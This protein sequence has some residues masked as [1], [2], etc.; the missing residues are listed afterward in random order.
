M[1]LSQRTAVTLA[2]VTKRHRKFCLDVG[3]LEIREGESFG[4]IGPSGAGKSTL[5]RLISGLV[6]PDAGEVI[7]FGVSA[8]RHLGRNRK[9]RTVFQDLALFPHL[10][11]REQL[12]LSL[13]AAGKGR[14]AEDT[15]QLLI[16][17]LGLAHRADAKPL[18]LSGGERQRV[19]LGRALIA[20]PKLL[21]MDEPMTALD[22]GNRADLWRHIETLA[23]DTSTT[24]VVVTHDPDVA[25]TRCDRVAVISE[26]KLLRVG[27]PR[28]LYEDPRSEIVLQLLGGA[29]VVGLLGARTEIDPSRILVS[30]NPLEDLDYVFR[31]QLVRAE[32]RGNS[33]DLQVLVEGEVIR[34]RRPS[35]QND[36]MVRMI[37][38]AATFHGGNVNIGWNKDAVKALEGD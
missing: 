27:T 4:I 31:G 1:L 12:Q 10:D 35:D 28:E 20:D 36:P 3:H 37:A 22:Y 14:G 24:F 34:V 2:H 32:H 21:L 16:E 13:Q 33:I 29:N 18:A 26:G 15:V 7:V 5:L 11:T 17:R 23:V 6:M 38:H 8:E 19:A 25:L 30:L 9:I